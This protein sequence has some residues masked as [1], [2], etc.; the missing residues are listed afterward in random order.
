[1]ISK[2][3][4]EQFY[5]TLG[6]SQIPLSTTMKYLKAKFYQGFQEIACM[7]NTKK[8]IMPPLYHFHLLNSYSQ[9]PL[10]KKVHENS[11]VTVKKI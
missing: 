3:S 5:V 11:L 8:N 1:V 6:C 4:F 2:Q 10:T 7:H 9:Q